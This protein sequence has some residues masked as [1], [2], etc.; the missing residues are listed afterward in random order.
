MSLVVTT[1]LTRPITDG[2]GGDSVAVFLDLDTVLLDTHPGKY[3][4]ELSVQADLPQ[5]LDRLAEAAARVV[6]VANP[7]PED[8]GHVMDTD[9]RVDVLRASLGERSDQLVV[10]SC[11]HGK[12]GRCDC[13]KPGNGLINR[14]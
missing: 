2:D 9:H 6:V 13:A 3:G 8:G 11:P 12:D 7:P 10:V 14:S 4:P 5:A 1:E